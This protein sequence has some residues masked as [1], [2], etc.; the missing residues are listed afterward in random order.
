MRIL[1]LWIA[2]SFTFY[3]CTGYLTGL[4]HLGSVK[5]TKIK[6]HT[7]PSANPT[8][9]SAGPTFTV[10]TRVS[11]TTPLGTVDIGTGLGQFITL[12]Y[13]AFSLVAGANY[14]LQKIKNKEDVIKLK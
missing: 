7:G 13:I 11:I 2:F 9:P 10:T 14:V 5:S 3:A 6:R 12:S 4:N 8:E 1:Q